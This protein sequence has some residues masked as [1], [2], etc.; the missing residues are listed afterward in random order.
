MCRIPLTFPTMIHLLHATETGKS[1]LIANWI[2]DHL[3]EVGVDADVSSANDWT[4]VCDYLL[5]RADVGS[6]NHFACSDRNHW[7]R[8]ALSS[9]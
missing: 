1:E 3:C 7:R 2:A 5:M 8:E 4:V 9:S 6:R